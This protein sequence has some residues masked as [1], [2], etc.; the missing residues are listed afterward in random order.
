MACLQGTRTMTAAAALCVALAAAPF[1]AQAATII[2]TW[3]STAGGSVAYAQ[4]G[5]G[6]LDPGHY[7]IKWSSVDPITAGEIDRAEELKQHAETH[8]G[9]VL[10]DSDITH[11]SGLYFMAP[12]TKGFL[13]TFS[14]PD[15]VTIFGPDFF[16]TEKVRGYVTFL[17]NASPDAVGHSYQFSVTAVPEPATWAMM[18]A[19]F[20]LAGLGL[21]R[22]RAALAA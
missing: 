16:Y 8:D 6:W 19:G 10:F 17:M 2:G 9:V 7:Q 4:G 3:Q 13:A 11:D 21:R 18:I 12:G 1:A 14:V 15:D 5:I 20:A 22:R